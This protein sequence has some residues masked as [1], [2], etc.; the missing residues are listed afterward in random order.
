M[1][2]ESRFPP[3]LISL[4]RQAIGAMGAYQE[5]AVLVGG[6]AP[7]VYQHHA[8]FD[9]VMPLPPL[10]TKDADMA[11]PLPLPVIAGTTLHRRLV[12]GG[13]VS[14]V[15]RGTDG[16]D[17]I[18]RFFLPGKRASDAPYLEFLVRDPGRRRE[19]E[20]RPQ[21][22]LLAHTG[23]YQELLLEPT[24]TWA[25]PIPEIGI[26]RVP[27]PVG[28]IAQKT[29][30]YDKVGARWAKDQGD[31]LLVIW[32]FRALW[33]EMAQVWQHLQRRSPQGAW[34]DRVVK[35]WTRLYARPDGEGALGVAEI[36]QQR[37]RVTVSPAAIHRVMQD[38]LAVIANRPSP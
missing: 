35:I 29:R 12:E 36:Y 32:A 30:M 26:I 21:A 14:D 11:V 22:D 28:Y 17:S 9:Q 31:V 33:P 19:L 3:A 5:Q 10:G 4:L 18:T 24:P 2:A 27:H 34:L 37:A 25:V 7:F 8:A 16:G 6:L 1:S 20:G 15:G 38:F 13:L 23:D